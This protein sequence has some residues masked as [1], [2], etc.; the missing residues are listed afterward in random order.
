MSSKMNTDYYKFKWTW[1]LNLDLSNSKALLQPAVLLQKQ[2]KQLDHKV[3]KMKRTQGL[4]SASWEQ[5]DAGYWCPLICVLIPEVE[6]WEL[7]VEVPVKG[8]EWPTGGAQTLGV[9]P[10]GLRGVC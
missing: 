8:Q 1:D 3:M 5:R 7:L 2:E 9:A 4:L 6:E 10:S